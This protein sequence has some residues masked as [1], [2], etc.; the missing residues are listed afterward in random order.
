[1]DKQ[2]IQIAEIMSQKPVTVEIGSTVAKSAEIMATY[3]VGSL[4]VMKGEEI[5]GM[6]TAHDMVYKVLAQDK[7]PSIILID[8]IMSKSVISIS[9]EKTVE[10]A[11]QLLNENDIKQ[12]PVTQANKLVGFITMKDIL[13]IEPTLMDLAIDSIRSEEHQR[14]EYLHNIA[15][16]THSS[17]IN[18]LLK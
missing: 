18:R 4:V 13:R 1:M 2:F 6:I 5:K 11:M 8:N 3:R 10:D 16:P 14:K 7:D 12:L 9:P 15:D 17:D